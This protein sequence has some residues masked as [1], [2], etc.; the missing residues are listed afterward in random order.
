MEK[1]LAAGL[2]SA[3]VDF[4]TLLKHY[5]PVL[6]LVKE[7]I[8]VIPNCDPVLEIWPPGFRSYNLLGPVL[9][10]LHRLSSYYTVL[11][12]SRL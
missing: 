9:Q 4:E 7:L 5:N 10:L 12:P 3:S 6:A 8:G 1:T 2:Q 11:A